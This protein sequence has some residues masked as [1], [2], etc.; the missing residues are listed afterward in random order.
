ML[1]FHGNWTSKLAAPAATLGL[2]L[3]TA[4]VLAVLPASCT[5]PIR[6][7]AATLLRPGQRAALGLRRQGERATV[8]VRA[9]FQ[10]AARLADAQR[11]LTRLRAENERLG[12]QLAA[13]RTQPPLPSGDT[14]HDDAQRLLQTRSVP[15]RVLGRQARAY[16]A[17]HHLLD[18]GS[19]EGVEPD[20]LVVAS[21]ALIDRGRDAELKPGQLVLH[22][23]QVWGKIVE[24][25]SQ[26]STV[27]ALTEPGYRDLVAVG[28]PS[29][30][31]GILE[32]TGKP[33][34]RIRLVEATEPLAVGD[35]VYTAA[36]QG[37]LPAS[38]L[39]G[40]I[41][42][43]ERPVGNHWEIWMQP[44]VADPPQQVAVLRIELNPLRLAKTKQPLHK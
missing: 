30:P 15:A 26:T 9:H 31:Q 11:E 8:A 33:L 16:L 27:R 24:L 39:Y 32:G 2:G 23:R 36:G 43:L 28:S 21:P 29:G 37:V 10:T 41:V 20:A 12:A 1:P 18:V 3:L 40:R 7:A 17:R 42:R 19:A 34:A 25:G 5:D 14:D 35:P 6:N 22:G 38:L 44:A 4:M 13:A